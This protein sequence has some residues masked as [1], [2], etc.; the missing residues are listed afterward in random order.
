[1]MNQERVEMLAK[2]IKNIKD[3]IPSL[4]KRIFIG[5]TDVLP[6]IRIM[7]KSQYP[8]SAKDAYT[9]GTLTGNITR[10]NLYQRVIGA[11]P[12]IDADP[13][14]DVDTILKEVE[15]KVNFKKNKKFLEICG[16]TDNWQD[17]YILVV[18][19]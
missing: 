18:N 17:E 12:Q 8:L 7:R 6:E 14:S 1:M 3:A 15:S 11:L 16:I 4:N 9:I 10:A 2:T 19:N 13:K 5:N